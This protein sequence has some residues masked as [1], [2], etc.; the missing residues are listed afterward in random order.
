M[1]IRGN[2]HTLL[3]DKSAAKI[4][5][6]MLPPSLADWGTEDVRKWLFAHYELDHLEDLLQ[7]D[8]SVAKDEVTEAICISRAGEALDDACIEMLGTLV[9][10]VF[11]TLRLKNGISIPFIGDWDRHLIRA[12]VL[13]NYSEQELERLLRTELIAVRNEVFVAIIGDS[14]IDDLS[15]KQI[16]SLGHNIL[17]ALHVLRRRTGIPTPSSGRTRVC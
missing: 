14:P 8:L 6:K 16:S 13:V 12:W 15:D 1:N 2:M 11:H 9:L 7:T 3:T 17:C 10:D 5:D 4:V